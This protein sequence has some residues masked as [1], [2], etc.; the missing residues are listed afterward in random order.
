M[1]YGQPGGWPIPTDTFALSSVS[2]SY[3]GSAASTQLGQVVAP[4]G[5]VNA[6]G[7]SDFWI[8][9]PTN[10]QAYLI[11]GATSPLAADFDLTDLILSTNG[12]RGKIYTS[13]SGTVGNWLASAGDV[14][15]D[16]MDDLLV[17]VTGLSGNGEVRLIKGSTYASAGVSPIYVED[18]TME[19]FKLTAAAPSPRAWGTSTTTSTTTS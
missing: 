19:Y 16:G 12:A 7:L 14:D 11:Y 9:D 4:A 5:D 8:G 15:G 10:A 18:H 6:D 1:V 2:E 3:I 13:R 17:G